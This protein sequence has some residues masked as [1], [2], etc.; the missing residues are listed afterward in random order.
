MVHWEFLILVCKTGYQS[1][2]FVCEVKSNWTLICVR[3]RLNF[4]KSALCIVFFP[5]F[6]GY[7]PERVCPSVGRLIVGYNPRRVCPSVGW[8]ASWFMGR[9]VRC[10]VAA[11]S[12]LVACTRLY[13]KICRSASRPVCLSLNARGTRLVV[14]GLV[15]LMIE[16]F[17]RREVK[18]QVKWKRVRQKDVSINQRKENQHFFH[19][20][21]RKIWSRFFLSSGLGV[22]F[23]PTSL[24]NP[25]IDLGSECAVQKTL[26]EKVRIL[27][28]PSFPSKSP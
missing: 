12:E 18:T 22:F 21:K 4:C 24:F 11:S 9:L 15:A 20:K 6:V 14:A 3:L 16:V 8:F 19:R 1:A 27:K 13:E 7:N 2:S 26:G 10:S 28:N 17:F 25:I 23:L 5:L